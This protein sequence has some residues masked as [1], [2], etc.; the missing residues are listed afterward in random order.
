M[1]TAEL[2]SPRR[3][4][5]VDRGL[6][7]GTAGCGKQRRAAARADKAAEAER[8]VLAK[9]TEIQD[10]DRIKAE[11]VQSAAKFTPIPSF[12]SAARHGRCR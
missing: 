8:D 6:V 5:P 1:A 2:L 9:I 12:R 7:N 4:R 10:S 3:I 11:R